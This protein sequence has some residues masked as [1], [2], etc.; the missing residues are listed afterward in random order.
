M[1]PIAVRNLHGQVIQILGQQI[2]GGE[3]QPGYILPREELLAEEMEVSRSALREAMKVLS[4]KGLIEAR[5]KV[6][7]RVRE[8][9]Y[10]Q[11]LDSD[12]LAWR[13]SAMPTH[14][15]VKKLVEMREIIEPAAAAAA[16]RRRNAKQLAEIK[17]AYG[18]MSDASTLDEWSTADLRFH[19]MM[20]HATNNELMVSLFAVVEN[21]LGAYFILSARTADNFKY[22]LAQHGRVVSAIARRQPEAARRH[23]KRMVDDSRTNITRARKRTRQGS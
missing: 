22:S 20:L 2:V 8:E 16:A 21:A 18:A 12:V 23:M 6:G 4:A 9:R 1:K 15:F 14:D 7:T 17:A 3:L 13:C 19:E 10:W 11:Q 5:P